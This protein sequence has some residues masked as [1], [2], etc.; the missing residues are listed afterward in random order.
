MCHVATA[1]V[2]GAARRARRPARARSASAPV[3]PSSARARGKRKTKRRPKRRNGSIG[4]GP[5]RGGGARVRRGGTPGSAP[6]SKNASS[7]MSRLGSRARASER[8]AAHVRRSRKPW[9]EQI[10]SRSAAAEPSHRAAEH[11]GGRAECSR[12]GV[13]RGR[14]PGGPSDSGVRQ[15]A[16]S[17]WFVGASSR[18]CV[19]D[20][21][22]VDAVATSFSAALA[23]AR[24]VG[25]SGEREARTRVERGSA[26]DDDDTAKLTTW[27]CTTSRRA[28][29]NPL[30]F[31]EFLRTSPG[32]AVRRSLADKRATRSSQAPTSPSS[33]RGLPF[34]VDTWLRQGGVRLAGASLLEI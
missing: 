26:A 10:L 25:G 34:E 29:S 19:L 21:V 9:R 28:T 33:P 4:R 23:S 1:F 5:V 27:P 22:P 18:T 20:I 8:V 24:G 17:A 31:S 3:P 15:G 11:S 14:A 6:I 7:C 30:N 12:P 16:D 32:R 13:D 2:N